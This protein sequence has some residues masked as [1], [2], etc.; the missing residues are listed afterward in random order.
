M[1]EITGEAQVEG[2]E[3][4]ESLE[5]VD[6]S[7]ESETVWKK[8]FECTRLGSEMYTSPLLIR[9]T[10]FSGEGERAPPDWYNG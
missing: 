6:L 9:L 5:Q 1:P 8:R 2:P 10:D 4:G 7:H 3:L